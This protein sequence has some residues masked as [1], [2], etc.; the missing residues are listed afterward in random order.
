VV[1]RDPRFWPD[2]LRFDPD[3]WTPE[4]RA[5]RPKFAYFPFGAGSRQCIAESFASME[6]VLVLAALAQRWR[7]RLRPGQTVE[8]EPLVTLRPRQKVK[9]I[10]EPRS[11]A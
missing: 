10:V 5:A 2:P 4:A 9:M 6:G 11:R 7:L 3:R 8:P 1:H